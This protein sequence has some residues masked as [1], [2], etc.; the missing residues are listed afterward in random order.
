MPQPASFRKDWREI[1]IFTYEPPGKGIHVPKV[2]KKAK[3]RTA[4]SLR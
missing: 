4:L 1:T 3:G 2:R